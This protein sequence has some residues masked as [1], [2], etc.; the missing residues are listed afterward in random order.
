MGKK[1]LW[2]RGVS[3]SGKTT[4]LVKEFSQWAKEKL[5]NIP[6]KRHLTLGLT[7]AILVFA[8]NS[9]NRGKLKQLL[10]SAIPESYPVVCKTPL[11]FISDEVTLFW[12]LLFEELNLKAQ[13]PLKLRPETEQ[14]LATQLWRGQITLE[15]IQPF[16]SEYFF[17]RR[18]LDLL[19]LAGASSIPP[20]N[21]PKILEAGF[22][23]ATWSDKVNWNKIG[24]LLVSWR[25]WCLKRGLLSYGIIYDLYWRYLLPNPKYKQHLSSRYQAVFADDVDDYPAICRNLFELLLDKGAFGVF[26]YNPYGKNRLGLNADPDYLSGLSGRTQVENYDDSPQNGLAI[27]LEERVIELISD[28]ISINPLKSN[29]IDLITT[30][31]RADLLRKTADMIIDA[32]N[33]HKVKPQEIAIIAPGIEEIA[34][35]TLIEILSKNDIPIKPINEQ[36][37]LISSPLIRAL[38]TLLGL[39]Y[40]GLGRLVRQDAVA[41]MLVILSSTFSGGSFVSDID[42]VRGGLLADHCYHIDLELPCLLP[43]DSFSRWDRLGYQATTAYRKI[44]AWID[45]AKLLI[46]QSGYSPIMILHQAIKYFFNNGN[47][48]TYDRL[49]SLRELMETAQHFWE[50]DKRLKQ[51]E[52]T[53][54]T[55]TDTIADF[56]LLLRRGT[57]T[58]NPR[59][60]S[61]FAN[62]DN[63]VV[64]ANVFQYRSLRSSHRWHFWLD[65][66]S[67]FWEKEGASA[68]FGARLFL[69]EWS[70][71]PII[72]EE[73]EGSQIRLK[74][75]IKDLL[76]RAE[77]KIYLCHSDLDVNGTEQSGPLLSLIHA[78]KDFEGKELEMV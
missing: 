61:N 1:S 28:P 25:E 41:E 23:G 11:G 22:Q 49:S 48:M 35:Y 69:K 44:V 64:F 5:L 3:R 38:L 15:E 8:A 13:F 53:R 46:K 55:P 63:A 76:A 77:E 56:I 26:T 18:N 20:E 59:P 58:A 73:F 57:I 30:S 10:N 27:E 70:G 37:P 39:V 50:V 16:G 60:I 24:A 17:I 78:V 33:N 54:K 42:P 71:N 62:R 43:V 45:S 6:Y 2:I 36:R 29:S 12:P 34:R 32:V 51:N 40:P 68:L 4:R 9:Y 52:P 14:E 67:S 74:G 19:Q 7:P 47:N 31:N 72:D 21:I 75:I 65:A 66:G